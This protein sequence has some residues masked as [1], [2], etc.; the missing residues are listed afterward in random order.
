M[1]IIMLLCHYCRIV[2]LSGGT[3]GVQSEIGKG[4]IFSF[5]MPFE[6]SQSVIRG[7]EREMN[8]FDIQ[9]FGGR[10][11]RTISMSN[12]ADSSLIGQRPKVLI[13]EDNHVN[14]KILKKLLSSFNIDSEDVENGKAAVELCRS[15]R[16]YD[17]I[18]ID[19]EMPVMDGLQV[20]DISCLLM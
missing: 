17:M 9:K 16:S 14:Q 5:V 1:K 13:V 4:S 2:E 20:Y 7:R 19:K 11:T 3:V 8:A 10:L 18:L 15:G 12:F 6:I